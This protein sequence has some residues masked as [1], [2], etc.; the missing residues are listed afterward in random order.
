MTR[1]G[2]SG[3]SGGFRTTRRTAGF[4]GLDE[5]PATT[6]TLRISGSCLQMG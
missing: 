6:V 1:K 3:P 4:R 5:N 2:P